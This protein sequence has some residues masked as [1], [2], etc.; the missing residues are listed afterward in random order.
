MLSLAECRKILGYTEEQMPDAQLTKIRDS[1][2]ALANRALDNY[3]DD[4][5]QKRLQENPS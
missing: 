5:R 3:M 2:Y 1:L 4:V